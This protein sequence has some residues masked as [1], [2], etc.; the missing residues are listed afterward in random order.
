MKIRV[1]IF[2]SLLAFAGFIWTKL[3][4][5]S[6]DLD[7]EVRTE[8]K[9]ISDL[10]KNGFDDLQV[11]DLGGNKLKFS[12]NDRQVLVLHF[13]ATW[14]GPCVAEIPSIANAS[15]KNQGVR[16]LAVSGDS[17]VEEVRKFLTSFE[18]VEKSK[19]KIAM[20]L[21]HVLAEKYLVEKLPETFVFSKDGKLRKRFIGATNW[22]SR[23][24]TEF[25]KKL[26]EE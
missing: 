5:R 12:K 8:Q 9:M 21:D 13:W 15:S 18:E 24:L 2:I 1:F 16:F 19:L 17:G 3:S 20:D 23:E 11:N 7:S 6:N 25:L 26:D 10:E 22:D 4:L 14:C